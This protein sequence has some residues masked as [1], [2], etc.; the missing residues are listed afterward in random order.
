MLQLIARSTRLVVMTERGRTILQESCQAPPGEIDLI[1]HGIRDV[2][3]AAPDYYKDRF[4]VAG[5]KL[6]LTFGLLSPNKGNCAH[7][8]KATASASKPSSSSTTAL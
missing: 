4:G 3:F 7:E 5:K 8:V 6:L 2:T 1:P